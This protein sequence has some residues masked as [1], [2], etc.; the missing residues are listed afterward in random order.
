V[1]IVEDDACAIAIEPGDGG[2]GAAA[3]F[4]Q[5][6]KKVRGAVPRPGPP[7]R[8]SRAAKRDE[9]R[10]VSTGGGTR[11]VHLVREEGRDASS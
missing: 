6:G 11:R 5:P 3:K 10:P 8:S 7:R 1:G 4:W 2:G 9:T